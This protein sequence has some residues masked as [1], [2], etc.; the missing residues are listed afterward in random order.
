MHTDPFKACLNLQLNPIDIRNP[1]GFR[2]NI[3]GKLKFIVFLYKFCVISYFNKHLLAYTFIV[4]VSNLL[5]LL[6][7]M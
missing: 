5:V 6:Q 3:S 1:V 2:L 4:A 7:E